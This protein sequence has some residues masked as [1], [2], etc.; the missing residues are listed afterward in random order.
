MKRPSV[1]PNG[2]RLVGDI[3]GDDDLVIAGNV[4][5]EVRIDG[6]LIVDPSGVIRGDVSARAVTV[7]GVVVGNVEAAES[8]RVDEGGRMVGD[9]RAPRVALV[10]GALFRGKLQMTGGGATPAIVREPRPA[11]R[12]HRP[13]A[14]ETVAGATSPGALPTPRRG[15]SVPGSLAAPRAASVSVSGSGSGSV[16]APGSG[17]VSAPVSVA[18][19]VAAAVAESVSVAGAGVVPVERGSRRPRPAPIVEVAEREPLAPPAP[20]PER[21]RAAPPPPTFPVIHRQKARRKDVESA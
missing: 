18:G 7:R 12:S 15:G 9:L 11:Y 16:S 2:L 6:I 20:P 10:E 3:E 14:P 1:L 13:L 5:G 8:I 19:T 4:E 21:V 17:S